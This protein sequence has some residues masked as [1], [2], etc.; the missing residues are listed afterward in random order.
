VGLGKRRWLASV[1]RKAGYDVQHL[2][3]GAWLV[4]RSRDS[5]RP[6]TPQ[7]IG[8]RKSGPVL[9]VDDDGTSKRQRQHRDAL[10][11][12]FA[13]EHLAWVLQKLE[14][15]C[16]L[17][18]GANK[19]QFAR[20]LRR[21]GFA[22]R[23][24][25]FEPVPGLLTKLRSSAESDPDWFVHPF[26][27]G[28][29]DGTAEINVVPGKMS[30]MREPS[31]FGR[32]WATK[33]RDT[34]P[35]TIEVRRL[36]SVLDEATAGLRDPRILLKLD[37]QGFDLQAFRGA[38]SRQAE[39]LALQ[40]ELACVPIYDGMPRMPEQLSEYESAGFEISGLFPVTRHRQTMRVIEFDVLMVRPDASGAATG[41]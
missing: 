3:D 38:G 28:E 4:Q 21:L 7:R 11:A 29:S 15:N 12:H 37:T 41:A 1:V 25:S 26:A 24:A 22:G 8:S 23:I 17:D 30:S 14:I 39:M 9:L 20:R 31:D 18:V 6:L 13:D 34:H 33:L 32:E 27:L 36:D 5:G 2:R 35:E 40:S 10:D 19:G 16:V